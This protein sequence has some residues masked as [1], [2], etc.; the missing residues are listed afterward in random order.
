[1]ILSE[2]QRQAALDG[3]QLQ[4]KPFW[5]FSGA[6]MVPTCPNLIELGLPPRPEAREL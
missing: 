6:V 1:M 4:S 5:S 2:A 3:K